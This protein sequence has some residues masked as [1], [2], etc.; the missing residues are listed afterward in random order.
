MAFGQLAAVRG[1]DHGHMSEFRNG[2]TQRFIQQNLLRR[3]GNMFLRP[4]H[5]RHAHQMV[6]DDNGKV[7]SRRAVGLRNHKIIKLGQ[8]KIHAAMNHVFHPHVSFHGNLKTDG[9]R[10]PCRDPAL[11]FL[12]GKVAAGT[13]ITERLL[14]LPLD[15]PLGFQ[16]FRCAETVIGLTLIQQ[17]LKI[18]LINL[19]AL[20]LVIRFT[21]T[22]HFRTFV[23]VQ[24]Q[25]FHTADDLVYR[26]F[27]ETGRIRIFNT[28]NQF[29]ALTSGKQPVEQT[30]AGAAH[31]QIARR[32]GGKTYTNFTH[33]NL[34][35]SFACKL[36]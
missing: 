7:V 9:M 12:F 27:L 5:M 4:Q 8:I 15:L 33:G 28:Q 35:L 10:F 32:A 21:G 36:F 6:V 3:I 11:H 26:T 22:A 20:G 19:R 17:L 31:M 24:A 16:F 30:G 14:P 29:A 13:G 18:F 1:Q 23:P 34:L 2:E 25:P